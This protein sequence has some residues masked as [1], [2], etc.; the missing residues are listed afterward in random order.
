MSELRAV[1]QS[2]CSHFQ[3]HVQNALAERALNVIPLNKHSQV[4]LCLLIIHHHR[5]NTVSSTWYLERN[6][7]PSLNSYSPPKITAVFIGVSSE[8][9]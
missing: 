4:Q 8:V 9:S 5:C 6:V 7:I 2:R 3:F 1:Y